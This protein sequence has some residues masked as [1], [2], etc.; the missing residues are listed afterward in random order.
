MKYEVVWVTIWLPA[1][2]CGVEEE[3]LGLRRILAALL[4]QMDIYF[5]L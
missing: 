4:C 3:M 5:Y 1:F 2:Q